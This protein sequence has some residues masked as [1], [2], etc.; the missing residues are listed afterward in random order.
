MPNAAWAF[1]AVLLMAGDASAE[2]FKCTAKNGL[3]LY[4]NFPCEID[5]LGLPSTG[6]AAPRP[7]SIQT[8]AQPAAPQRA[9]AALAEP[10]IGMSADAVRK[11]WGEPPE[12][13]QD[14]PRSGRVEI[15]QYGDGRVVRINQK[16]RV[17]SIQP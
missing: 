5:S 10:R 8:S 7:E 6:K 15:W 11:V 17:I 2:I 12:I 13:L 14:E 16:Q 9:E 1:V 4:Q 3:P